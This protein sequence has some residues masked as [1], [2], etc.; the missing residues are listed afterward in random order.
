[1]PDAGISDLIASKIAKGL[2]GYL[3]TLSPFNNRRVDTSPSEEVK[4]SAIRLFTVIAAFTL[5][6]CATLP[7]NGKPTLSAQPRISSAQ[8]TATVPVSRSAV[9]RNAFAVVQKYYAAVAARDIDEALALIAYDVVLVEIPS[10]PCAWR[11]VNGQLAIES[12]LEH[13]N[14]LSFS[15]EDFQMDSN[16]IT[17]TLTEWLDPRV[18]GPNFKQPV[19]SHLTAV[20]RYG[21]ITN[22][23]LHRD[24]LSLAEE[25]ETASKPC[26]SF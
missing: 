21:E 14:V 4:M 11:V 13:S 24:S 19:R 12:Q 5:V 26:N 22:F 1:M 7:V 2:N 23:I 6:G 17:Y 16:T 18:V 3:I 9:D 8:P 25:D 20:V 15:V 10:S